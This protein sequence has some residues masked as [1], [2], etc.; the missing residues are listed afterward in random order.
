MTGAAERLE[1]AVSAAVK[2]VSRWAAGLSRVVERIGVHFYRINAVYTAET[3]LRGL[4]S[5]IARKNGWQLAEAAGDVTPAAMQHL[6][7]RATWSADGVRDE[8]RGYVVEHLDAEQVVGVF[9]ETAI[10]KKGTHSVGVQRQYCGLTGQ[11]ENCQVGV[12][13]A[14][15]S[16][17]GHALCDRELY[18]PEAWATDA[19]RRTEAHVPEDVT[20]QTKPQLAL[21]MWQRA[22]AYGLSFPWITADEVY[23]RDPALRHQLERQRQA[24]VLVVPAN[25]PLKL[26][27]GA[28]KRPVEAIAAAWQPTMWRRLSCGEGSKGPRVYDWACLP[29]GWVE[30]DGW[31]H[32]LLV[33]RSIEDPTELAYYLVFGPGG[34]TFEEMVRVAGARWMVEECFE[35]GKGEVG[36]DQYEVRSWH[37]WYRHITLS[38]W[39][40]AFLVVTRAQIHAADAACEQAPPPE[41]VGVDEPVH[42]PP[43]LPTTD[44]LTPPASP[45][46]SAETTPGAS[47]PKKRPPTRSWAEFLQRRGLRPVPKAS[48]R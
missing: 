16:P 19:A 11:V 25:H 41:A 42:T 3:Y 40:L 46:A 17:K 43:L 5:P 1:A 30:E 8:L 48:S 21:Q 10:L 29:Y 35:T 37:G 15:A 32:W 7:N 9:D 38:M 45:L 2:E 27:L 4:L 20:F 22:R 14:Y 12:F 47:H 31:R 18:L 24:F 23:G 28:T 34:T 26:G 33:R 39:A 6:L 36:L 44:P 13:L